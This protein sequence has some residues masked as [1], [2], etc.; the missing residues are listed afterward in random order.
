MFSVYCTPLSQANFIRFRLIISNL[1][2]QKF[3]NETSTTKHAGN[4]SYT[5]HRVLQ[6]R[7]LQDMKQKPSERD[8]IFGIAYELVRYHLPRPSMDTYEPAKWNTFKEYLPHV[9]SLQRAYADPLSITSPKPFVGLAELFKNGGILLW[10]RYIYSDALKLL[11]SAE[12]ILDELDSDEV[13][14]R[15]EINITVT[16][17]LQYFGITHRRESKERLGRILEYRKSQFEGKSKEDIPREDTILLI[18]AHAD[19]ANGLLQ[20]NDYKAAEPIYQ[21]CY[22]MYLGLGAGSDP[23]SIF[24]LAK[25]N[26]HMAYCKMYRK[27][28]SAANALAEKAVAFIERLGDRQM[29]LRYQ[30]DQACIILQSGDKERALALHREILEQ[31]L[32]LQGRASYFSLQS[33]YAYAGLCHYLGRVDEAE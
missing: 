11:N 8:E 22:E 15:A 2:T 17:L 21:K 28:F 30:F 16:L 23:S 31:R 1:I 18:D 3:V 33:Q 26:H 4:Q 9:L 20:F 14:M 29:T 25:L 6:S 24:A 13:N 12:R 32:G 19:Y 5:V 10:Q 7:L 27:E